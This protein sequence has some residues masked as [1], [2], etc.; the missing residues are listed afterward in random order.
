VAGTMNDIGRLN[1]T[2]QPEPRTTPNLD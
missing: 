2:G 1:N